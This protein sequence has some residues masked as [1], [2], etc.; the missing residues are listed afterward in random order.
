MFVR[1]SVYLSGVHAY[2]IALATQVKDIILTRTSTYTCLVS[3]QLL[4]EKVKNKFNYYFIIVFFFLCT[5]IHVI[6]MR[7]NIW[8]LVSF[9]VLLLEICF[10]FVQTII[11]IKLPFFTFTQAVGKCFC[12]LINRLLNVFLIEKV[13]RLHCVMCYY[14]NGH[15]CFFPIHYFMWQPKSMPYMRANKQLVTQNMC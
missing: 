8:Y 14:L 2:Y 7:G 11:C 15:E 5:D 12:S 10:F 9:I 13:L 6:P 4:C 1:L 3:T